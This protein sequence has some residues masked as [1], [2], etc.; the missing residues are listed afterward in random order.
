MII[1][2]YWIIDIK[3]ILS[4]FNLKVQGDEPFLNPK[5]INKLIY[6]L[7]K[8]REI[9]SICMMDK[10]ENIKSPNNVKVVLDKNKYDNK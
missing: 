6:S 9:V 1:I 3:E 10:I 8:D 7:S 5:N 4:I 2:I